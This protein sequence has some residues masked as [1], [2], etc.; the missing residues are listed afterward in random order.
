MYIHLF[1]ADE[2]KKPKNKK[3]IPHNDITFI[4]NVN[5]IDNKINVAFVGI[6]MT[7]SFSLIAI[8]GAIHLN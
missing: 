4:G 7:L 6:S 8:C 1:G 3:Y 2:H 5:E